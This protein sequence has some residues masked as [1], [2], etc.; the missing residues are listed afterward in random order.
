MI[1][2]THTGIDFFDEQ[3]GGVYRGRALLVSGRAS[4][5]KT[6][7]GLQFIRQGLRLDERCLILSTMAANDLTICAE[8]VGFS[9]AA[10]L[11]LG[12]LILLE[13][14]SFVAGRYFPSQSISPP[15]GFSQLR[16]IIFSNSIRRVLLDTVLPWVAGP[17]TEQKLMMEQ[18]FS[19]VRAFDRMGVTALM[20]IPKPASPA[21]FR[22]KTA[23][24]EVVPVSILLSPTEREG[25]FTLQAVKYLGEKK[26]WA[27]E[28]YE[29]VPGHGLLRPP[30]TSAA[31]PAGAPAMAPPEPVAA[32]APAMPPRQPLS[33]YPTPGGGAPPP[34]KGPV[35]FSSVWAPTATPP[36]G[37]PAP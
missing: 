25:R 7:L 17:V 27:P 4:T 37:K 15:E 5:G 34:A 20:T 13:Y 9:L 1:A 28:E 36:A 29:I 30:E 23:L 10:D 33:P 21:A 19:F 35:R 18:V 24:E 6:V 3:Y 26:L 12:N 22:L 16:E 32:Q 31:A 11:D 14:N 2:K 8:A